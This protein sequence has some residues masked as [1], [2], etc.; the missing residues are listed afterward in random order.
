MIVLDIA[1]PILM[2]FGLKHS[3][4]GNDSLLGDFDKAVLLML[5]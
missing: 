4:S 5:Y 3:T 2:M 1:A